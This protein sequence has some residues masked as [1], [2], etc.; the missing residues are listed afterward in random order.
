MLPWGDTLYL[1]QGYLAQAE[2]RDVSTADAV[3]TGSSAGR[4]LLITCMY[5]VAVLSCVLAL[6][7]ALHTA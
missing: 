5:C 3:S 7:V 4:H 6:N 2:G 1:L